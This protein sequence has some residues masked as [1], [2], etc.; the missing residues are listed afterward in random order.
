[1]LR[2]LLV[3]WLLLLL[4]LLS[5]K[6]CELASQAVDVGLR[7]GLEG[8]F[9][10]DLFFLESLEFARKYIDDALLLGLISVDQFL[11]TRS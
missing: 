1:M 3:L 11:C 6:G 8:V 9:E 5:T 2:L 10:L 7:L 4:L